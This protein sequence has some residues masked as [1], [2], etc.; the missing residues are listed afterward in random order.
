MIM[1]NDYMVLW[2]LMILIIILV[3]MTMKI[4]NGENDDSKAEWMFVIR[5]EMTM[6]VIMN[7]IE[8][9]CNNDA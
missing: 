7:G 5:I 1:K 4:D 9:R 2:M 3:V 8:G 6:M